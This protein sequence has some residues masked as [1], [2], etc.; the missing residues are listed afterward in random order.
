MRNLDPSGRIL[1][2]HTEGPS[3]MGDGT[4][5][6]YQDIIEFVNDDHRTLRSK[7]P[8]EDGAWHE[9]MI[10]HSPAPDVAA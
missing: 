6:R 5:A 10:A 3:A 4:L 8:C 7:T 1:T 2:F 9:F